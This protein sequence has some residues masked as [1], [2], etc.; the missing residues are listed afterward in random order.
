MTP[1]GERRAATLAFEL[2][3]CAADRDRGPRDAVVDTAVA[4]IRRRWTDPELTV[5][6]LADE[7]GLHRTAL[8]RRFRRAR[9]LSPWPFLVS[10]QMQRALARLRETD[11]PIA[12]VARACSWADPDYFARCIRRATGLSPRGFRSRR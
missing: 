10:L 4:A 7:L 5:A 11:E 9:G 1:A 8:A 12:A 2:L 6:G 3:T